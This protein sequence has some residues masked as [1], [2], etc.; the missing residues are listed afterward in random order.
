MAYLIQFL[1][2]EYSSNRFG[3]D[4]AEFVSSRIDKQ[5]LPVDLGLSIRFL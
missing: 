3:K 5:K 2:L 4:Q 1:L